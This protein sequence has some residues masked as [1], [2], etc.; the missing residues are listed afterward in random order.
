MSRILWADDE[1]T[2]LKPHIL[3]LEKRGYSIDTATNGFDAVRMISE[4]DYDLVI[5]DEMMVGIDGLETL[6][7]IKS[8]DL[9]IKAVMVTKSEEEG[10]F[11]EA[12]GNM[13]DDYLTKPVTPLQLYL[14]IRK[15][16]DKENILNEN[17]SKSYIKNYRSITSML[18]RDLS[19]EDWISISEMMTVS[20]VRL[21]GINDQ[22]L[23]LTFDD[24]RS[25]ANIVFGN[26]IQK[27]YPEWVTEKTE[28][29]I[30]SVDIVKKFLIPSIGTEKQALVIIDCMPAD[31]MSVVEDVLRNSFSVHKDHYFSILPTLT[32]FARNSIFSGMFPSETEMFFPQVYSEGADDEKSV[33]RHEK[34]LLERQLER[35]GVEL[36]GALKYFK[37]HQSEEL[38]R[39]ESDANSLKDTSLVVFVVNMVDF[40]LHNR[41]KD[42]IVNEMLQNESSYRSTIKSWFE[43]SSL[44]RILNKLG[45]M[46][47]KIVLT[48]DHG[49]KQVRKFTKITGDGA[50]S[51]GLRMKYG[52]NI[53]VSNK[54]QTIFWQKPSDYKMPSIFN[55]MNIVLSKED[56]CFVFEKGLND[57]YKQIKNTFQHGGVSM[58]EI[59][60][61]VLTLK[62]KK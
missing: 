24:L 4:S 42:G 10:I 21:D 43:N 41:Q 37:V 35:E 45:E 26:Y 7:R 33:N 17:I 20:S 62:T 47:F 39:I 58:E 13:I 6:R 3:Y 31:Q 8:K 2:L 54:K 16:L 5:L 60:L 32:Q 44:L 36:E 14:T 38:A 48:T 61:P 25:S 53:K 23:S 34:E 52:K 1:I 27:I 51:G 56:H 22:S 50:L 12:V 29:P 11:L 55:G 49:A 30:L 40:L 9:S 18:E 57:F 15:N 46:D 59:I 19:Y 28:R